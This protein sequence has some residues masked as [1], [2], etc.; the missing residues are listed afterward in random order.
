MAVIRDTDRNAHKFF[1]LV[2]DTARVEDLSLIVVMH[3]VPWTRIFFEHLERFAKIALIL[4][5]P[6]SQDPDELAY[7]QNKYTL[8]RL[9]R[10][11]FQDPAHVLKLV[12]EAVPFGKFVIMDIG[13]YFAQHLEM[14]C[15][16]TNGRLLGVVEDTENGHKR[17]AQLGSYP[18]PIISVARSELKNSEDFLVGQSIVFSAERLMREFG[19]I[20]SG[21]KATVIGYG[22]I[23]RSIAQH[24]HSKHLSTVIVE[25]N[26]I[27]AIEAKAHGFHVIPKIEALKRG[28]LV[29]CATGSK[30]ICGDEFELLNN[31][32]YV[33]SVTSADDELD[34]AAA[35][36][37]F[38][39][40][41]VSPHIERFSR[42]GHFFYLLA[43]GNAVNFAIDDRG[44]L[45][46]FIFPVQAEFLV[47]ARYI[48]AMSA[49]L[50]KKLITLP[51]NLK[52]EI[53]AKWEIAYATVN[54]P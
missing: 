39:V 46:P 3:L 42:M 26:P 33:I 12:E 15:L 14:L 10:A 51:E 36:A 38:E 20:M 16:K 1:Q 9:D 4:P 25:S 19:S 11:S 37:T 32:S 34:L 54:A 28:N 17:Y 30:C 40:E 24:L 52:L 45:G 6:K 49:E 29:F 13:G 5:K 48:A 8:K 7:F 31:G 23:G 18:V 41:R 21:R 53:A 2:H 44:R 43:K 27:R 35:R 22:K 47:A 50:P